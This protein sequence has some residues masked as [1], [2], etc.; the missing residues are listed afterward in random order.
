MHKKFIQ[1][2]WAN[3]LSLVAISVSSFSATPVVMSNNPSGIQ[4]N[5]QKQNIKN[6]AEYITIKAV[7]DIVAGTNFPDYRLPQNP[8][9]LFP[10]SVRANLQGTDILFGNY[11]ST[12][13]RHPYSNK[14]VSKGMVFA[15]RSPPEYSKLFSQV[16]FDVMSVANNHSMDFGEV[17]FKDTVKSLN[18]AG[19]K[20]IG[21]KNRIHYTQVKNQTVAW[22]GFC[23]YSY[24]NSVNDLQTA[25]MLLREAKQ[26]AK[27]VVISMHIG[28][29]GSD[30]LRTKNKTEMFY[31]ENRGNSVLFA[32]TMIDAGADLILG[33]GPHV[34]R[35]MEVY[36]GKLIAYSLGNFLGYRTFSTVGE[37]GASMILEAKL[38]PE[39]DFVD[40][41]ILPVR[42]DK[43]GIPYMDKTFQ[44]V[45]I[46]RS[47]T[48]SDFPQTPLVI[49]NQGKMSVVNNNSFNRR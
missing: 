19:V 24:C 17:G 32:R 36:N 34:P 40:G 42:L 14:D 9:T 20:P 8:N 2:S 25:K 22:I 37:K 12:L 29:E 4:A 5:L 43:T 44:S 45:N 49:N 39:G 7:G 10:K 11:E 15:F 41:K 33:H 38:N 16:G 21:V 26:K 47:L 31:G 23:F 13:T 35:A 28:A 1:H 3:L 46:V 18:S 27:I 30:A 48:K 6:K